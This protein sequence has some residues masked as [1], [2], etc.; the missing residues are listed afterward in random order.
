MTVLGKIAELQKDHY[1]PIKR[2]A[3]E[4]LALGKRGKGMY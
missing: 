1:A 4:L 2:L 3:Q